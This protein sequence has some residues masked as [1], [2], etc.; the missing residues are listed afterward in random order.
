MK[1][2]AVLEGVE[3]QA[4][5]RT[6]GGASVHPPLCAVYLPSLCRL[7]VIQAHKQLDRSFER[8]SRPMILQVA[9]LVEIHEVRL[10]LA[11]HETLVAPIRMVSG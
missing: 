9:L 6:V 11:V 1:V 2:R 10:L 8:E 3:V 5:P 7:R 4:V